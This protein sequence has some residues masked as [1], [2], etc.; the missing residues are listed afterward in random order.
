MNSDSTLS[1]QIGIPAG[2]PERRQKNTKIKVT[3]S[4]LGETWTA[5]NFAKYLDIFK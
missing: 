1:R 2:T 3:L 4:R 5:V